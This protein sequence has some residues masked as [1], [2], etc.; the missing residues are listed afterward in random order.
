M[1]GEQHFIE[2]R[3]GV[4]LHLEVLE[5]GHP[6]WLIAT[7]GIGEHLGRADFLVQQLSSSYNILRYDIRGHGLSTGDPA[8]VENFQDFV[9]DLDEVIGFAKKRYRMNSYVLFGHSMGAL[10]TSMYVK[11][12]ARKQ[13][14]PEKV[15]LSS[16]PVGLSGA[17]GKI[18]NMAS[19]SIMNLLSMSPISVRLDGLINVSILSHNPEIGRRYLEDK[20]THKSLHS[21]LLFELVKSSKDT[22]SSPLACQCPCYVSVGDEDK[23]VSCDA[24]IEYFKE[25][26]PS[27]TVKIFSEGFHE[28]HHEIERIR[29]P[30]FNYL[31]ESLS[32]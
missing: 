25:H 11:K 16:P 19:Y 17:T 9:L 13:F 26:E 3:D 23:I 2:L 30:Y 5:K 1:K 22:F 24:I 31:K 32:Y 28:L 18:A 14:Y 15:Y 8:Y 6:K 10:I 12:H 27:A 20:R 29:V 4:E 21:K 7:H